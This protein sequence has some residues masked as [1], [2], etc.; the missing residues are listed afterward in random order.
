MAALTARDTGDRM[1][2]LPQCLYRRPITAR[3]A[4][5]GRGHRRAPAAETARHEAAAN[6]TLICTVGLC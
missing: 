2:K 4:T 1:Q 3:L 6:R 5:R